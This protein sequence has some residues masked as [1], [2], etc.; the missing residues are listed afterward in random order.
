VSVPHLRL[1]ELP[2]AA[3]TG[4]I[5]EL[6]ADIRAVL[7]LPMVNLVYRHLATK[8][9]VLEQCWRDLRPNLA[10]QAAADDAAELVALASPPDGRSLPR[11]VWA[12][13]GLTGEQVRLARATVAAYRRA[14]S[15]NTLGLAVLL[16]GCPGAGDGKEAAALPSE[17]ILPMA[18]LEDVG[19]QAAALLDEISLH[20]VG[21][22]E[23]RLVPSLLRHFAGD[24]D[25]LAIVWT[26]L[27]PSAG[28]IARRGERV[29]SRART[30]APRLPHPVPA[31]QDKGERAVVRRFA[32][33]TARMLVLGEVLS[34]ALSEAA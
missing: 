4:R 31:L 15:L 24:A 10:S 9:G 17:P 2:E 33:A 1:A 16:E 3:A 12:A 30:L 27:R 5:A 26:A 20:V 28:E 18:P 29:A 34:A 19:P 23:P 25:V 6:Y 22:E 32:E 7:A 13:A 14:N 11:A 8:P 21:P